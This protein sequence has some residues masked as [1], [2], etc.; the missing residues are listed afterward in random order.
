MAK[1]KTNT[2]K[3]TENKFFENARLFAEAILIATI[4]RSFLF[5]PFHIPSG[6]MKDTLLE[7][8]FII[9]S[10]Y[11]YGY[12]RYS[13]PF[14]IAPIKNRIWEGEGPERGD[15]IVFRLPSNPRI[16]YIKRLIGLPGD[17]VQMQNGRLFI[18]E[19]AVPKEAD[20]FYLDKDKGLV[21]R[22]IETLPNGKKYKV[23]DYVPNF[24]SD[25]TPIFEVPSD[26]YF[27]MGDNRDNSQ[28][29]RFLTKVGFVPKRNLV[30]KARFIFMSSEGSLLKFWEWHRSVRG[31]RVF[32]RI[33]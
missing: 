30:G 7:G 13:F 4:I 8:D 23:L 1:K 32:S 15:V 27:F 29:S 16:N 12:S 22:Y 25:N 20:G 10:K 28:D 26:H 14:G 33:K 2:K 19:Q 17:K 18:N 31:S 5:E 24:P 3:I 11:T 21:E 6:S 9:V